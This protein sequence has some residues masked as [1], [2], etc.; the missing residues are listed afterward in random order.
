MPYSECGCLPDGSHS[1]W[2]MDDGVSHKRKEK[3]K[4]PE[5]GL[6]AGVS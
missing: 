4:W 1:V 6:M 5:T 2:L 3:K